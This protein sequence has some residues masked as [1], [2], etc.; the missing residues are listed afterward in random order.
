M[1]PTSRSL[2]GIAAL[3]ARWSHSVPDQGRSAI[4]ECNAI[5]K[6]TAARAIV[7]DCAQALAD[8]EGG[9]VVIMPATRGPGGSRSVFGSGALI[10]TRVGR[11]VVLCALDAKLW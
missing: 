10:D 8:H 3:E 5:W 6:G 7:E 11:V 9:N 4:L 2:Y 1:T